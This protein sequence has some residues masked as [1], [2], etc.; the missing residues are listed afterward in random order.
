MR[1]SCTQSH[2]FGIFRWRNVSDAFETD[3][4]GFVTF[5]AYCRF[6][7]SFNYCRAI[8]RESPRRHASYDE[9]GISGTLVSHVSAMASIK[10]EQKR[11]VGKILPSTESNLINP[12]PTGIRKGVGMLTLPSCHS[13]QPSAFISLLRGPMAIALPA[14][15]TTSARC[16]AP[17]R[18]I[19]SEL[20]K[21]LRRLCLTLSA[22]V[23]LVVVV[24][25]KIDYLAS[26]EVIIAEASRI[27]K[28]IHRRYTRS[29]RRESLF[30]PRNSIPPPSVNYN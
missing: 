24:I 27:G 25:A 17:A 11:P 26:L 4:R 15:P 9:C 14:T 8:S 12:S 2:V 23:V 5:V 13:N 7:V 28:D 21:K 29:P 30:I 1:F 18:I 22:S 6:T 20:G 19:R 16:N 3:D 10:K